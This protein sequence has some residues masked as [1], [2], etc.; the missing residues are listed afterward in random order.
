APIGK[1]H[2]PPAGLQHAS[3]EV[4]PA[5]AIE[6][7]DVDIDPGDSGGPSAPDREIERAAG[8]QSRP[9]PA[10]L[11]H[12]AGD[13]GPAVAVEVADVDIHPGD[14]GGP[15]APHSAAESGREGSSHAPPTG[16][17]ARAAD[18]SVPVHGAF[19]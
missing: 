14:G 13:V 11:Q 18:D 1:R 2:P 8:T 19:D 17:P 12:A 5:V 3:G 7:A 9:P 10:G 15:C 6:V 16:C 4:G